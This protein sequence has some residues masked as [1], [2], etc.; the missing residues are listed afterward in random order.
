MK[1]LGLIL[2]NHLFDKK[3]FVDFPKDIFMC[4]DQGLCTHFKY[5]KHKIIHFLA[6]MR[7][8]S[9]YLSQL[10]TVHYYFV[11]PQSH[12]ESCLDETV[13]KLKIQEIISYEIEDKFFENFITQFCIKRKIHLNIKPSPMFLCSHKDFKAFLQETKKPLLNNFYIKLRKKH[14]ILMDGDI[15]MGGQWNFDHDNRKKIPKNHRVQDFYPPPLKSPHINSV[16]DSVDLYFS[17]HHGESSQ[18]WIPTNRDQAIKWFDL[19]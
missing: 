18:Y 6:S 1:K 17:D 16:K 11:Q 2:G 12:F 15:P 13:K 14:S 8:F 5:H 19:Y 10:K 4:E 7:E 3:Y 9:D